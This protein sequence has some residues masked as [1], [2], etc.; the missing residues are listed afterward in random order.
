[1]KGA[2]AAIS[3]VIQALA[4]F[5]HFFKELSNLAKSLDR[6]CRKMGINFRKYVSVEFDENLIYN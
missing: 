4:F 6:W 5:E 1:M 3:A 2:P